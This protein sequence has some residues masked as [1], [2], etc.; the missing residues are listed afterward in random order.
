MVF[1]PLPIDPERSVYL[2][3]TGFG[4]VASWSGCPITDVEQEPVCG[5][6]RPTAPTQL[7]GHRIRP[8]ILNLL[9]GCFVKVLSGWVD[10][11]GLGDT[12]VVAGS[13]EVTPPWLVGGWGRQVN[14]RTA[15]KWCVSRI[16]GQTPPGSVMRLVA[17]V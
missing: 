16:L 5:G 8:Y 4:V 13:Y 15:P 9:C 6:V 14:T 10:R 2:L 7:V 11:T 12:V 3:P 1:C 17:S